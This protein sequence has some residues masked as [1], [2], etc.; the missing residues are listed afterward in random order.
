MRANR[1]YVSRFVL[2]VD[3]PAS[4]AGDLFPNGPL[5]SGLGLIDP[6]SD[7]GRSGPGIIGRSGF[8]VGGGSV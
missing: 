2:L 3:F 8:S 7:P 5:P 1:Y 4:P 6:G